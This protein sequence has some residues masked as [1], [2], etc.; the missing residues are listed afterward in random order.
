MSVT[1]EQAEWA[2]ECIDSIKQLDCDRRDS[3]DEALIIAGEMLSESQDEI[4]RLTEQLASQ[5]SASTRNNHLE[6]KA[7]KEESA[8]WEEKYHKAMNE[9]LK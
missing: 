8:M 5:T 6:I 3:V 1:K 2:F 7:L 9:L 4:D